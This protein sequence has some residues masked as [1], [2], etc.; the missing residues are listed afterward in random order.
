LQWL[1]D[2]VL[3]RNEK[4]KHLVD[5]KEEM[6]VELYCNPDHICAVV[7]LRWWILESVMLHQGFKFRSAVGCEV[8]RGCWVF[9]MEEVDLLD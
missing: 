4:T 7:W 5:D 6:V 1:R 9:A 3:H 8:R 2:V